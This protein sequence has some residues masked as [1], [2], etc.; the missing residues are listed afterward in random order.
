MVQ[1]SMPISDEGLDYEDAREEDDLALMRGPSGK[2]REDRTFQIRALER[3]GL[4]PVHRLLEI[5][6]GPLL[7]GAPL[8]RFLEPGS[9]TG[10]D[11]SEERLA[12]AKQAVARF[13]LKDRK[14]TLVRSDDFGLERLP[15]RSFDRIWSYQVVLHLTLPLVH[16][17]MAA[18]AQLLKPG[19]L[20]WFSAKIADDGEGFKPGGPW[21]E[22]PVNA[23]DESF[24]RSSADAAGLECTHLGTLGEWGLP[25]DRPGAKHLLFQLRSPD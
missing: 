16:R 24:Y 17:F 11:V 2:W 9:Y 10:V 20:A 7:A 15:A 3:L 6:C 4:E 19:G 13:A 14:P 18:V 22:F 5:G 1:R 12:A 8:I 21:L 23:A 25:P